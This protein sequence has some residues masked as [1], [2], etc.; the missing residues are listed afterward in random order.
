[1]DES[2]NQGAIEERVLTFE[3]RATFA[4]AREWARAHRAALACAALLSAMTLQMFAVIVR[5]SI[6]VDEIVLI[7]AAYYH[8]AAFNC[9][10]VH[11]H[12]PLAKLVSGIPLLLVQPNEAKPDKFGVPA[13]SPAG[14]WKYEES[15]W[16]E[17]F[18]LFDSLSF[19]GRLPMLLLS[20]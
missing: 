4:R 8:W 5:K 17:N 11:E 19:W 1:M 15:F 10:L 2:F 6:T 12:P 20:I 14:K 16:E 7:P 9:Q 3:P 13:N 18:A